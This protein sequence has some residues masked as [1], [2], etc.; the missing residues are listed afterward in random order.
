MIGLLS[1]NTLKA[2]AVESSITVDRSRCVRHRCT[3]NACTKC[4]DVCP[5]D[6][7]SWTGKSLQIDDNA[8]TH[9]LSCLA[10]CPTAAL[11]SPEFTLL[12]LLSDLAEHPKPVIGCQG[13]PDRQAHARIPCLGY[14][15]H[16]EVMTLCALTFPTGLQINLT[17]CA[18]CSNSQIVNSVI[19]T[20]KRLDDLIPDHEIKLVLEEKKLEYL[21]PSISRRDMFSLLRQRTT[22][23]A[24]SMVNRLQGPVKQ[25]SYGNKQVPE[26]RILLIRALSTSTKALRL[27]VRDLLFGKI[28]FTPTCNHSERCVG[29]CPTGAIKPAAE[30]SK[31]P[32]FDHNLCVSCNSCQ[33]FCRNQGVQMAN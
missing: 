32:A 21:A 6:A 24:A 9:C 1:G 16:P 4:M 28:T 15:A 7:I 13:K 3:S 26:F 17:A 20:Q 30:N 14:L 5:A 8:C 18:D 23:A 11:A 19:A 2:L 22:H 33:A 12:K 10:V 29:V 31:S 25:N 27:K